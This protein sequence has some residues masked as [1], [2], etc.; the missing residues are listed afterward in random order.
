MPDNNLNK[1]VEELRRCKI[2]TLEPELKALKAKKPLPTLDLFKKLESEKTEIKIQTGTLL[3]GLIGG[4]L[5]PKTSML[6]YGEYGSGKSQ[7]GYTMCA[8]C[9]YAVE[10]IDAENSF[11]AERLKQICDARGKD[12]K[13]VF[14][15]TIVKQPQNWIQQMRVLYSLPPPSDVPTGKVGLII[16]DSLTKR[17]R[18]VEFAG[19]QA[20]YI[21][22]PLI[23]E[24][25]FRLEEII[26]VYKAALIITTQVYEDVNATSFLAE[27]TKFK[28][29]GGS[30]LLHQPDFVIF[31]R[32]AK[33]K[34]IRIARMMD[35]SW[36]PLRECP[37]VI[38]ERGIDNLPEDAKARKA[39][40]DKAAKFEANQKQEA[41]KA[42]E[43]KEKKESKSE[44]SPQTV[45][46]PQT[47]E[48]SQGEE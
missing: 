22:Q 48:T 32:R 37:F 29:V 20:L 38:T 41:L 27:W 18:G 46:S 33:G 26:K 10:L 13:E 6:L 17:F 8:E 39:L 21:K 35:S 19:R 28:A 30:S 44:V 16:L 25:S 43:K 24:F 40:L 14:E 3:D 9:P 15:K 36:R 5:P 42:K 1:I 47:E 7:T 34:N 4:G 45:K 23:R 2:L 12:Y 11:R 31:L